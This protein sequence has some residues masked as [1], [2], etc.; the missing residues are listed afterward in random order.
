MKTDSFIAFL[1]KGAQLEPKP[2]ITPRLWV[3]AS[4]GLLVSLV[5]IVTFIGLL[6]KAAFATASPW[7]KLTY[8]FLL[9]AAASHLT[10]GL[11]Q[12]L[13]HLARPLKRLWIVLVAMLG[14]GAWTLYQTP[15]PDRLDHLLGQT[16]LVCPWTVLLI[17]LPSLV[18]IQRTLRAFAPTQLR[19]AGFA[20]GLLAGAL[21]ATAYALACPEDSPAFVAIWYTLGIL[22][23]G[24]VGA[25]SSRWLMRW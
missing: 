4:L 23:T 18:V 16:W 12:P 9:V 2:A 24:V 8:T 3:A 5:I 21:G 11:S 10:A 15:S 6:P 14:V 20:C 22:M 13:A 7:V 25:F 1:A 17:S 19:E